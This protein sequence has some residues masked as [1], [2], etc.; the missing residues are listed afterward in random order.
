[1]TT[2]E[3]DITTI[4]DNAYA[5]LRQNRSRHSFLQRHAAHNAIT[6]ANAGTAQSQDFMRFLRLPDYR[7]MF[8]DDEAQLLRLASYTN[9]SGPSDHN[10]SG[11]D[12]NLLIKWVIACALDI[13]DP[14]FFITCVRAGLS[15][16]ELD[17]V[18]HRTSDLDRPAIEALAALR[19][20]TI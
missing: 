3:P 17:A 14:A 6:A 4:L 5:H 10:T 11:L 16:T 8:T 9:I 2:P 15:T 12:P 18:L 19:P 7:P 13:H 20:P 1:M